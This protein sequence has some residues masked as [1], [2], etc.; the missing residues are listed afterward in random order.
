MAQPGYWRREAS[1]ALDVL[2]RELNRLFEE[3]VQPSL[4]R[5]SHSPPTDLDS[6]T[7]SPAAD[8][9]EL[10]DEMVVVIEVPGVD[11]AT[12]D[13]SIVGNVMSVR[14]V[15]VPGD[16]PEPMLV[17]RERRFGPFVRQLTLPNDV[18]FDKANAEA[19]EGLLTIRLPKPA[20]AQPRTIPIRPS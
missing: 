11:P 8:I 19:K 4:Y 10:P 2:Q 6:T 13:L 17:V 15:K 12:I 7:W 1:G 3:Y 18:D 14:G 9:Y 5:D 16:L 20:A